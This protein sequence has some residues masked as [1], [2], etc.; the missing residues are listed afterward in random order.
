MEKAMHSYA[1]TNVQLFNQLRS[2]GYSDA[3]LSLVRDAY[4]LAMAL[5]TG[6]FQPSGKLFI[7]HVVGTASILASLRLPA[8]VVAAGLIHN[9]FETGDFGDG[10]EAIS[11]ARREKIRRVLGPAG[12]EYVASFS[13]LSW[14]S[15]TIR[16]ARD[17]P[18]EL[19][20]VDRN[21]LLILFADHLEHLLD[22]DALYYGNGVGQSYVYN[23][24][25][26]AEIAEKLGLR[27][28]ASEL[29]ATIREVEFAKLPVE[30]SLNRIRDRS[31]VLVPKSC[32]KRL[33]VVLSRCLISWVYSC[34]RGIFKGLDFLYERS[35]NLVKTAYRAQKRHVI[36]WTTRRNSIV[37][38]LEIKSAAFKSL[39]PKSASL[40]RIAT[41]FQF[42]EG[43]VWIEEERNLL[44][45]DIPANRI[46]RLTSGG[47]AVTFR[48]P[49]G[50]ANG[51]TRDKERRLIA[52]EHG[53]RR[54]TRTEKDGSITMA[55]KF[56][57]KKLNSPNDVVVKSDGAIYFSD[58]SYGIKPDEQEQPIQGVYRLSPD[59]KEISLVARDLARPNGLA[60]SPNEKKLYID[61][62]ERRHVR[63]FDVQ[64]DGS[65]C[66]GSVFHDMNVSLPGSPDGMKVDVEGHVY[67]AG[68]G[69]VWVFDTGGKHLGTIAT[70]EKPSNCAWGDDDWR[71][72]YITAGT[73]VYKIRVNIP[74][75]KVP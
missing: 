58:P 12:E 69:G 27:Q 61:D 1:Q 66:G 19:A 33:P 71:G 55:D 39:F 40:Q 36:R 72:L 75:I 67:C 5:F 30:L 73:S 9:V 2:G 7:A 10:R 3:D 44:F 64:G 68:A 28:L 24:K 49:S 25:I 22:L 47:R 18:D 34:R 41:G 8:Q 21:G 46:L 17:H 15:P 31:F 56:Q 70:P 57:G 45:S 37:G 52:C 4:E 48:Q 63:V 74:G 59:G 54:V 43:P 51:L 26:A 6:R 20:P 35:P 42:T 14:K 16:L 65:L 11:T 38:C 50:N 13:R 62:S 60:F 29:E 53:N 23:S 32:R